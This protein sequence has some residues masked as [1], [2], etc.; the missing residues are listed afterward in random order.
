MV[1]E[2]LWRL[3]SKAVDVPETLAAAIEE[4]QASDWSKG[5]QAGM[6]S[7]F[8]NAV[9]P[10]SFAIF[11]SKSRKALNHFAG[12]AFS[13]N[14]SSYPDANRKILEWTAEQAHLFAIEEYPELRPHEAFDMFAHWLVAERKFFKA[15]REGGED[16]ED[17]E[18]Q[19]RVWKIA[20]GQGASHWQEWQQQGY[21][22]MG[23]N[24]LGDLTGVSRSEFEGRV[25]TLIEANPGKYGWSKA[26]L[27]QNWRFLSL[28][29]GDAIL[30]NRGTKEVIGIGEVV[31]SYQ[32]DPG[33]PLGHRV[34]VK[35]V[36]STVRAVSKPGWKRTLIE[37]SEEDLEEILQ[38]GDGE[39]SAQEPLFAPRA[40]ELLRL[41]RDAPTKETYQSHKDELQKLIEEPLRALFR[42]AVAR[43][44][45]AMLSVL[46]TEKRVFSRFLKND[47]G[48]G[49]AWPWLW[50]A[51]YPKGTKRID[52]AQMYI[53]VE[54]ERVDMGF[55]IEESSNEIR[56]RLTMNLERFG[57]DLKEP[58]LGFWSGHPFDYGHRVADAG[59]A[60]GFEGSA[61]FDRV[62]QPD[63]AKGNPI[64]VGWTWRPEEVTGLGR[65]ALADAVAKTWTALFPLELMSIREDPRAEILEFVRART[66]VVGE[67]PQV[68]VRTAP[69]RRPVVPLAEIAAEVRIP[70]DRLDAWIRALER[71]GQAILYGPPGTGKTFIAR[72]LAGHLV[73]GSDGFI[74]LLQ[75]HPSYAY[76]DFIQGLRPV[77]GD[78]GT[79]RFEV[80]E[81][82]FL[83]F[84][85]KAEARTG[86]CVLILDEINRANLS[87]VFGELMYLLEYRGESVALAGGRAL[88]IPANVRILGTMNT[89]DRSIALVD[90][91]LRRRFA[92]LSLQPEYDV[93]RGHFQSLG[94]SAERLIALLKRL[95]SEIGDANYAVGVSFFLVEDPRSTIEH[96]WRMEIEPYIEELFFDQPLKR[97]KFRWNE[98]EKE[99]VAE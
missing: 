47:Y 6:I 12:T 14:L 18:A 63:G 87:R 79:V 58:L 38:S 80:I 41:L 66:E 74:D 1:A 43:L 75:F 91:A 10:A 44:P 88:T 46:E 34:P 15:K 78:G 71:K 19:R 32:F 40:F 51:A 61:W 36:D 97:D 73:G 53:F 21:A 68:P 99:L 94:L 83:E 11:N 81:G 30:V 3:V 48:Q 39:E 23:P 7:P 72:K 25:S 62:S 77:S 93:L 52:G 82:R 84:C 27:E 13:A 85:R 67:R 86:R 54:A 16:D 64:R 49:G 92:F 26:G 33:G 4:F 57:Q 89:A 37:I 20:A 45:G 70:E 98:I 42:E 69:E 95:N 8:L 96:V 90:H 56:S 31:G 22:A 17:S 9:A 76:E 59:A 35:W 60:F 5:F 55:Y 28:R 2:A 50:A 24:E 29:P 65:G